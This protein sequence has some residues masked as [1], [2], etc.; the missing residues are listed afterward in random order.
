MICPSPTPD[1]LRNV[2]IIAHVDHGK[3]TLVDAMLRQ[4]GAFQ[5]HEQ[6]PER[7]LDSNDLERERGITILAKHTSVVYGNTRINIID[8][9][10]HADFGG[11]VERTL[12]MADG[13]LLLVDAAEGPLPQT[14]FV[15]NKALGLG[16]PVLVVINKVDRQDAR[17]DEVLDE[18]FDLFCDLEASDA[19]ADFPVLYTIATRGVCRSEPGGPDGDLR[20]LFQTILERIPPPAGDPGLPLQLIVTNVSHDDYVG[21]LAI[22]RVVNG[23]I[24]RGQEVLLLGAR[25]RVP[26]RVGQIF[27]FEGLNRVSRQL[28]MA[29]DVIAVSGMPEVQIGDTVADPEQPV[30][31][32]RI[33]VEPPTIKVRFHVNDSPFSGRAGKFVTSSHLRARLQREARKNLAMRVE[34]SGETDAFLVYCRGELMVAILA[35]TMRR[36]GYEFGLGNP[37]VVVREIDGRKSEPSERVIVDIPDEYVGTVTNHR[38]SRKGRMVKMTNLGFGRTR[39]EFIAPSRGLIGYRSDFLSETRGTGLLNTQFEGWEPYQGPMLRRVRGALVADRSG[40]AT[41]YA[42]F[43][44]QARGDLFIGPGTEVYEGMIVGECNRP[45]DIDVNITKE[46]KLTNLRAAAKDENV[47]L[48]PPR[49]LTLESAMAFIDRDE[50][51]EV[52]PDAIRVRKKVLCGRVRPRRTDER[53]RGTYPT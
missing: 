12:S 45:V 14:R 38:G 6:I 30:A 44:M 31:L 27:G 19:Q 16:M 20:P 53:R 21:R 51:M 46:K 9:P 36:E 39:I 42:L 28:A 52:T 48:S 24:G 50:L 37:E 41:A 22:G 2:A 8:T 13:A 40:R 5:A 18:V 25:E 11:E 1:A 29:G 35:E 33:E 17:A 3:T 10:G 7:V 34:D 26:H 23:S 32:P 43:H 15:L 49:Q 47:I 4:T